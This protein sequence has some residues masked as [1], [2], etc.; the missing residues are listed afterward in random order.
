MPDLSLFDLILPYV[1]RGDDFGPW[2]PALSVLLVTDHETVIDDRGVVIRGTVR[3]EGSVRPAINLRTMSFTVVAAN[4]DNHPKN[5]PGQRTP[6]IDIRDAGIEF[7]LTVPRVQSA[8]ITQAMGQI[9]AANPN[10]PAAAVINAYDTVPPSDDYPNTEFTLDFILT[11]IVLRPPFLRGAKRGADGQMVADPEN[12]EVKFTLPKIKMRLAQGSAVPAQMTVSILSLG[13]TGLDDPGSFGVAELVTMDPPYA[14]IGSSDVVA[15]GFRSGVLDLSN[16]A[17]PPDVLKQFGYDE[18]WQGL[19]LPEIRLFIAPNGARDLA[20]DGGA[21]NLLIGFGQS[22][23]VTG[24][25]E[26]QVINQGA[27]DLKIGARFY[28]QTG[29]SYGITRTIVTAPA[30]EATVALPDH[31]RMII[32]VE[33]GLAP[34]KVT[35][36]N[37]AP[38]V[39]RDHTVELGPADVKKDIIIDVSDSTGLQNQQA[40]HKH[41][42]LTI[43]A[44]RLAAPAAPPPG[45]QPPGQSFPVDLRT[46]SVKQG[47][48]PVSAPRLVLIGETSTQ[49]TIALDN[50]EPATWTVGNGSPAGPSAT[51]TV[52]VGPGASVKVK[53]VVPGQLVK[54]F[55]AFYRFDHPK[56]NADPSFATIPGNSRTGSAPDEGV[57]SVWSSGSDSLDALRGILIKVPDSSTIKIQGYVS[58]EGDDSAQSRG[59][60]TALAQRRAD[61]L[62]A[63]IDKLT[64]SNSGGPPAELKGRKYQFTPPPADDMGKWKSQGT[65]LATR[66]EFWKALA[67]FPGVTSDDTEVNGVVSRRPNQQLQQGPPQVVPDPAQDPPPPPSWFHTLG[68]KVRIVRDQFVACEV[69]GKF[70]YQTA[71]EKQL[72]QGGPTNLPGSQQLG[73]NDADG[74]IDIRI[75]VQID[76]ATDTVT[77]IG[78]FGADPAD[79]DG[80]VLWGTPPGVQPDLK[81]PANF[82]LDFLGISCVFM[83]AI[84]AA[85]SAVANNGALA[86]MGVSLGAFTAV[87]VIAGFN[88]LRTERVV[89][90]GGELKVVADKAGDWQATVLLDIETAISADFLGIITIPRDA[91]LVVRYKAIGLM[92]GDPAGANPFQFRPMFDSSKGY[93][94]DV[95]RPGAIQV[96]EPLGDILKILGARI[97]KNNPLIFDVDL[98]FAIDLGVVT[99]EQAGIR[100]ILHDETKPNGGTPSVELSDFGASVDIANAITGRG[101]VKVGEGEFVGQLDLTIVPVNVRIA[102]GLGIKKIEDVTAVIVKLDVSFPVAI[103]LGTSGLGIYGFIGLFAMH[104]SRDESGL[105]ADQQARALA[106]LKNAHGDPTDI[107][108]WKPEVGHWAFGVGALLGTMGSSVIFNLKGMVL[109]ELPGPRLLLMLKANF[110]IPAPKLKSEAEGL[111]LAVL[112]LDMGRGTLTIGISAEFSIEYLLTIQIP[113]EAF[114]NFHDPKDWHLYLGQYSKQIEADVLSVFE[115]SG[116]LMIS[117]NGLKNIGELP[118][119]TGFSIAVGLH[120]AFIWGSKPAGLYAELAAGFDAVVGF[121]PFRF[122]GILYVR[123]SL[124]LWIIDIS[125]WANLKVDMGEFK[126]AQNK[127]QKVSRIEG[128]LCG[129]VEFLFFTLSGCVDF[130]VGADALPVPDPPELVRALKLISRSPALVQGTGTDRPIDGAYEDGQPTQANLPVVPIDTI[131][132]LALCAPPLWDGVKFKGKDLKGS[133]DAPP[134]GWVARGDSYFKYTLK[135]VELSG[136]TTA[137]ATPATWW[138]AKS[139]DKAY[140]AQLALLS[141]IPEATPKAIEYSKHLEDWVKESWG[142]ICWPAAPPTPV[143]WTFLGELLGPSPHGWWLDGTAWPDPPNTVRSAPTNLEVK[144]TERWRSGNAKLDHLRAVV[145][146]IVEGAPVACPPRRQLPTTRPVIGMGR[147]VDVIGV[148]RGVKRTEPVALQPQDLAAMIRGIE[149]GTPVLRSAFY[150]LAP[151]ARDGHPAEGG[152]TRPDPGANLTTE[153]RHCHSR[154]LAAPLSDDYWRAGF[155]PVTYRDKYIKQ[156]LAKRKYTYGP[157]IDAVVVGTGE[158]K[159]ATFFLFVPRQLLVSGQLVIDILDAKEKILSERVVTASDALPAVAVPA[160]WTDPTGPWYDEMFLLFEHQKYLQPWGYQGVIVTVGG[161]RGGDRVQIGLKSGAA[162]MLKDLRHRPFYVAAIEAVRLEEA[163]RFDYDNKEQ[164]HKQEIA[165][166][167]LS[168]ESADYALLQKGTV[169]SV[170]ATWDAQRERHPKGQMPTDMKSVANISQTFWF[171]TDDQPPER[172]DPWMLAALPTE[173]ERHYFA[174]DDLKLVFATNN[175]VRLYETYDKRL[176][177][178][179]RASSYRPPPGTAKVPKWPLKLDATSVD[180]V[181]K[182]VVDPFE[183]A[184]EN[185]LDGSCVPVFG[186]RIRHSKVDIDTPLDTFTDY[187]LDIEMVAKNAPDDATG[188]VVWRRRFSTGAFR[189]LEAFATSFFTARVVHR[190]IEAGAMAD[191]KSRFAAKTPAGSELDQAFIDHHVEPLEV[192]DQPRLVVFWETAGGDPQPTALI[193]DASEPLWRSRMLPRPTDPT[194]DGQKRYVMASVPWL[195]VRQQAGGDDVLDGSIIPG[196]G[197]QRALIILKPGS[198]GKHAKFA[199]RRIPQPEP[200]LDGPGAADTFVTIADFKLTR[201]PWEETED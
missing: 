85:N 91:P 72:Q 81:A 115:G 62:R 177:V 169:Y 186:E 179:L 159:Q 114:F 59:Y 16:G 92:L 19:Y 121:D 167:V 46:T 148:A 157:L 151:Q 73:T 48:A 40:T 7:Q 201:A 129:E 113:I 162:Q 117:G 94:I 58:Y 47:T 23:G 80:L 107:T 156:Q 86:Q 2:H 182:S 1:L 60:N 4:A 185:L 103:P 101:Y 111:L 15:F 39:G 38:G 102:A 132:L 34:Y 197:N 79:R 54:D 191:I 90:Y 25:F 32:D 180:P 3:F 88:L 171:K 70:D 193:I 168:S 17:T 9:L 74:L 134:D 161:A 145:P 187:V 20:I 150:G 24:D 51:V 118:A 194:P 135:S 175:V 127:L 165:G 97:A 116:Y 178:R 153:P 98:G 84:S 125:A 149:R 183:E 31:T 56:P 99:I 8:K 139:G 136:T 12:Q 155:N 42:T 68:G 192:P 29:R 21:R 28:D 130:V 124:V 41:K 141:W 11:S 108:K 83:P 35:A 52:D 112:D 49:A 93:T 163:W 140:E 160:K 158:L 105:P 37:A 43:H 133:N 78:Y 64:D 199:L 95:A 69:F 26:L 75:V 45:S 109:L 63:M 5:D 152:A 195:E 6:W 166:A 27:G 122:A 18:S 33:G 188:P 189:T 181:S 142:T 106:W 71:A 126:D 76:E 53:A 147:A 22:A 82:G 143:L 131:P 57:N 89:W 119:V 96:K 36:S 61:G 144:V 138:K 123:G 65:T 14:F 146:A 77:V 104:W 174:D 128:E 198:R 44:S 137:G 173:G 184:L 13:A 164:K 154:V 55:T 190:A 170:T 120:V 87:G 66:R 100:V 30:D 200:Y 50:G 172:L 10:F 110:L 176:Q 196:P 67:S